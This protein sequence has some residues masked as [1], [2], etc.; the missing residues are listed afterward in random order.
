MVN[1]SYDQSSNMNAERTRKIQGSPKLREKLIM[2][3]VV[4]N[5]IILYMSIISKYK[6]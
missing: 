3:A 5:L 1:S 6:F 2:M 4:K